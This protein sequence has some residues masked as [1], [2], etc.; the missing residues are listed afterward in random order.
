MKRG[1]AKDKVRSKMNEDL[2]ITWHYQ[3]VKADAAVKAT[4]KAIELG[5]PESNYT[6]SLRNG[7]L[8]YDC[9]G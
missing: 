1:R 6:L 7:H 2:T 3:R 5:R 9:G 8:R 4:L